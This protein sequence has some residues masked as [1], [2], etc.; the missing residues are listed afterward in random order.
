MP[1][2]GVVKP[3][4]RGRAPAPL[5]PTPRRDALELERALAPAPAPAPA[6]P[7]APEEEEEEE[8]GSDVTRGGVYTS[9]LPM[10][11]SR[12]NTA[13]RSEVARMLAVRICSK[14]ASKHRQGE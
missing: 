6:P 11:R 10:V 9:G 8:E 13:L 12:P 7:V 3:P 1:P 4:G 14:Q 2:P 5:S